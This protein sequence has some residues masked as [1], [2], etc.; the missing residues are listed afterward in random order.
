MCSTKA[1]NRLRPT[2]AYDS[3]EDAARILKIE[4]LEVGH[5]M[6]TG[7]IYIGKPYVG[8]GFS[9]KLNEGQYYLKG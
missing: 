7:K 4:L 3:A 5:L 1:S 8:R 2:T 6:S 9:V